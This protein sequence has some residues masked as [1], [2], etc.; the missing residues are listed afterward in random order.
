MPVA[1]EHQ[2]FLRFFWKDVLYQYVCLPFGLCSAPRVFTKILKPL[3]ARLRAMGIRLIIYLDDILVMGE[4]PEEAVR[5]LNL[6]I[7]LLTSVGFLINYKK[8]VFSPSQFLEL[9]GLDIDT[10][11]LTLSLPLA[12]V[13]SFISLCNSLLD[14]DLVQLRNVAKLLGNFSWSIPTVPFAQGHSKL[15]QQFYIRLMHC[16]RFERSHAPVGSSTIGRWIK[17]C[18]VSAGVDPAFGANSTRGSAASKAV[19]FAVS[20]EQILKAAS[21]SAELPFNRFYHRSLPSNDV[22]QSVLTQSS[23]HL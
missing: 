23:P 11:N 22:A 16:F 7:D 5:H 4:S 12:K 14:N 6:I 15:L 3:V 18:L 10:R 2:K 17:Q 19:R 1:P 20:I 8:S 13:D 21:W 9:F